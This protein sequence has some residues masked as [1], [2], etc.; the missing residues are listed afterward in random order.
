MNSIFW[1]SRNA[2][3]KLTYDAWYEW[4]NSKI[5]IGLTWHFFSIFAK[6]PKGN[7]ILEYIFLFNSF[8][9]VLIL[10]LIK[11]L[12]KK[13]ELCIPL[14]FGTKRICYLMHLKYKCTSGVVGLHY[15]SHITFVLCILV[16]FCYFNGMKCFVVLQLFFSHLKDGS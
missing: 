10:L 15:L 13:Y 14:N 6:I 12:D 5:K 7:K 11:Y 3:C 9:L 8:L 4:R 1:D 2:I 16:L